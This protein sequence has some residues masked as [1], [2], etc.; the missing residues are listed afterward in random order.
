MGSYLFHICQNIFDIITKVQFML[1]GQHLW[2]LLQIFLA[3]ELN[4]EEKTE[5]LYINMIL[6]CVSSSN[7]NMAPLEKPWNRM[8]PVHILHFCLW[9]RL[10]G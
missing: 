7:E 4:I 1:F 8:D 2:L 3:I 5:Q 6:C 9:F 10:M